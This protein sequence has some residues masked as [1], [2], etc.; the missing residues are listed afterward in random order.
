MTETYDLVWLQNWA[1]QQA[2]INY[3]ETT[4]KII[5]EVVPKFPNH[6]IILQAKND[7]GNYRFTLNGETINQT[8]TIAKA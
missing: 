3:G 7:D 4:F 6:D 2:H 5:L 1:S 8:F